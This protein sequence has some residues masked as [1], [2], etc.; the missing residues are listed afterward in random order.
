MSSY[1]LGRRQN[2]ELF[3]CEQLI[4]YYYYYYYYIYTTVTV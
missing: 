2:V 1:F 3:E 4:C